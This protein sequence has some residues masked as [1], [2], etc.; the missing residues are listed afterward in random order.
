MCCECAVRALKCMTLTSFLLFSLPSFKDMDRLQ[1]TFAAAAQGREWKDVPT[2]MKAGQVAFHHSLTLHG[3]GAN[4]TDQPRLAAAVHIQGG[5][6][7]YKAGP[8]H[9]NVRE[10]G[11]GAQDGDAFDGPCFPTMWQAGK[12]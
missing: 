6:V 10:L 1:S 9:P 5:D 12:E 3:S 11:P 4:N 2:E 8:W 7:R